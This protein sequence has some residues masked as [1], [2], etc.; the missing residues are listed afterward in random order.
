MLE[1]QF[2][3]VSEPCTLMPNLPRFVVSEVDVDRYI[4]RKS[5]CEYMVPLASLSVWKA[6]QELRNLVAGSCH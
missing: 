2:Y 3:L 6:N 4:S 5:F 1:L